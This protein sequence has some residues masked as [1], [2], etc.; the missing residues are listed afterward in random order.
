MRNEYRVHRFLLGGYH[1]VEPPSTSHESYNDHDNLIISN[2]S[3]LLIVVAAL[4]LVLSCALAL[5][6]ITRC[7]LRYNVR[8]PFESA[9]VAD[10]RLGTKGLDKN[11]LRKMPVVVYENAGVMKMV[12]INECPICLDEFQKGEN[13][14]IL[15]KCSHGY[16]VKCIDK[17][18]L[19][20]SSCPICRQ[21]LL[22]KDK[23]RI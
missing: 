21:S 14:R 8:Y 16:H 9:E 1:N 2:S 3:C 17:W 23:F 7:F 22:I 13:L 6:K 11:E 19:S 5:K 10:S 20:H 12:N 4:L 18:F 15:P